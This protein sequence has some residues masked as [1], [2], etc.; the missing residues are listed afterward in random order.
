MS[1]AALVAGLLQAVVRAS[2]V[3]DE[4]ASA[5]SVNAKSMQT[6]QEQALTVER[7]IKAV[8]AEFEALSEVQALLDEH[9][10]PELCEKLHAAEEAVRGR[11]GIAAGALRRWNYGA[12]AASDAS[13]RAATEMNSV[14]NTM[15]AVSDAAEE[16]LVNEGEF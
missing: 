2:T 10:P 5:F 9:L 7:V 16:L 4:A 12:L 11:L 14:R 1:N 3:A 8:R 6:L 13:R 15:S